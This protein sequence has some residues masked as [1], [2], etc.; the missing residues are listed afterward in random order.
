MTELC[1]LETALFDKWSNPS[2]REASMHHSRLDQDVSDRLHRYAHP[3]QLNNTSV[4]A[5]LHHT[6]ALHF[7]VFVNAIPP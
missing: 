2:C 1:D 6:H 7:L 4:Y 5:M 3:L